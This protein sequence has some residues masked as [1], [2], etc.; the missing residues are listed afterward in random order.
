VV[1]LRWLQRWPLDE[2]SQIE[3]LTRVDNL[4]DHRY[5]GSVIVNDGNG[6]YFEPAA[7]RTLQLSLRYRQGF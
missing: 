7:G 2:A 6:R 5:A 4:F 1:A 3:W